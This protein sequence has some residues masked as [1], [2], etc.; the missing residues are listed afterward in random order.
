MKSKQESVL[1]RN[2]GLFVGLLCLGIGG[3]LTFRD[4]Q[5]R[6]A[7][8]AVGA[9]FLVSGTLFQPALQPVF[10]VWM[11]IAAALGWFN[12]RLLLGVLYFLVF[13]PFGLVQR[14]FARDPLQLAR[15]AQESLWI[16]K[17]QAA[18]KNSYFRQF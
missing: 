13:T 2:F 14:L 10:R 17:A 5:P 12:T 18:D 15:P 9:Y 4:H 3:T 6:I 16:P 11:R 1:I 8:F 7:L